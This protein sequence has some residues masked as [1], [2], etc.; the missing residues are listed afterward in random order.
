MKLMKSICTASVVLTAAWSR[1]DLMVS[2]SF[3]GGPIPFGSPSGESFTGH[4][5]AA[6]SGDQVLGLSVDLN[7]SGGYNGVLY[8]YLVAPGGTKVT[9][10]DQPGYSYG[11][12]DFGAMGAGMNIRLQ[13]GTTDHGSIQNETSDAVLSGTYNAA[14]PVSAFNGSSAN[15]DWTLYFATK[16]GAEGTD[17]ASLVSW[18]L[19]ITVVPEPVTTALGI[20]AGVIGLVQVAKWKFRTAKNS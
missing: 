11:V 10:M 3:S 8:S 6:G 19:N 18:N 17:P 13:D 1:A 2:Q 14:S 16:G 12:N 7:I 4:F 15:G 5:T 9:L 20:F